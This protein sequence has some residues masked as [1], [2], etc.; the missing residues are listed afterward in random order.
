[1]DSWFREIHVPRVRRVYLA[2]KFDFREKKSCLF[3]VDRSPSLPGDEYNKSPYREE[4]PR[5]LKIPSEIRKLP[6][7]N[8]FKTSFHRKDFSNTP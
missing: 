1:M 8:V 3:W 4:S 6:S 5:L 7:L 2:T